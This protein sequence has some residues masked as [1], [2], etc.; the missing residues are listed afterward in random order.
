[1]KKQ[2]IV[3]KLRIDPQILGISN[4][5]LTIFGYALAAIGLFAF[6]YLIRLNLVIP[7]FLL[8][9]VIYMKFMHREL[10]NSYNLLHLSLLYL[11]IFSSSYFLVTKQVS[12]LL[13]PFAVVPM[14]S[15]LLF[16]DRIVILIITVAGAITIS[17]FSPDLHSIGVM[18][19]TSGLV[20]GILV[21]GA[22]RR[23]TIINC[24]L[25]VGVVQAITF[26]LI[27]H[28]SFADPARYLVLVLNGLAS[29]VIVL[30]VLPIF[31]YLFG[32]ITNIELLELADFNNPLLS[33]LMLEAPGTYHHSLIVGNLAEAAC[34]A[35]GANALLARI[36]AYYHDIGKLQKP[37]YFTENQNIKIN[38]HEDLAPN[39]S[40]LV[41]M[42]HIKEGV[43][44]AQKNRLNPQII[45]FIQQH[46]GKSLVYYFYRRALE[47]TAT[48]EAITEEGFRYP[49]P[50]PSSKETA[51]VLLADSVEAAT[52]ALKEPTAAHIEE[53]V[54]RIIN[55]KFIDGQL[56]ECDLTL[57]DM[58]MISTVFGRILSGIYHSRINYPEARSE[59]IHK[60]P[61]KED[62]R[63][64]PENKTSG[65]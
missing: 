47:D 48:E 7:I 36:G 43:E 16:N 27:E 11:I 35:I 53:T 44:L 14:L 17:R 30:G 54:H 46:H 19:L 65:S 2:T 32:K 26:F 6:S 50:K 29:A 58:E 9:L 31:E 62:S 18:F 15:A 5:M 38:V 52:R 41:I 45:D 61:A 25:A 51:V 59:I 34:K 60:K 24:G 49:G 28:M 57:K 23:N 10:K 63:Q 56:D 20:S 33:R 42:N 55:N 37:E 1:M 12:L 4:K 3:E 39:M 64:P 13:I 8:V 21:F 40:K 22:R